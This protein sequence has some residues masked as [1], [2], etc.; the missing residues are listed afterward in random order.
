MKTLS[1]SLPTFIAGILIAH[2]H[3][4]AA[5]TPPPR[6]RA[7]VEAVLA[8]APRPETNAPQRQLHVLLCC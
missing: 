6:S 7:E 1:F 2:W 8:K 5:E 4:P 3:A